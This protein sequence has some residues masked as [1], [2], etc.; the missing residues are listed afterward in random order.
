[1]GKKKA[2]DE[3]AVGS[4]VRVKPGTTVPE[5]PDVACGGWT[6][7]VMEATGKKPNVKYLI[8]WDESTLAAMPEPYRRTCEDQGLYYRMACFEG[9]VLEPAG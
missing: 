2:I 5:F 3:L 9:A 1:M 6:G 7:T 8:E 4:R